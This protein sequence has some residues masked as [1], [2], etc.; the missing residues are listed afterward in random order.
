M[1]LH[2]FIEEFGAAKLAKL[3]EINPSVVSSWKT[4]FSCPKPET[5]RKIVKLSGGVCNYVD[6]YEPYFRHNEG[7]TLANYRDEAT[8]LELKF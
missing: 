3:L 7:K 2:D 1:T 8:Q 5:A 6:I 4:Y